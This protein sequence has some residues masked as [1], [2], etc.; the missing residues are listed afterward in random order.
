[1]RLMA[2]LLKRVGNYFRFLMFL[3][4]QQVRKKLLRLNL[5]LLSLLNQ[6]VAN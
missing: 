2:S 6:G 4:Q 1:M 5:K 3:S